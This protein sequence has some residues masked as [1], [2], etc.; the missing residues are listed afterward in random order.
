MYGEKIINGTVPRRKKLA[1]GRPGKTNPTRKPEPEMIIQ[2]WV[3]A[4][5]V[6]VIFGSTRLTRIL[7]GS[8]MGLKHKPE[9]PDTTQIT[10]TLKYLKLIRTKYM[11]FS[12]FS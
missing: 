4:N 3:W 7:F 6:W 9:P 2:V 12:Q 10:N 8:G 11:F 5:R 1:D